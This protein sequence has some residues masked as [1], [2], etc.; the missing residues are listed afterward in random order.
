MV[1]PEG[2]ARTVVPVG[3][4]SRAAPSLAALDAYLATRPGLG[5]AYP[6]FVSWRG[7][8]TKQVLNR[9]ADLGVL[10]ALPR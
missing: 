9:R 8:I 6:L 10:P 1:R 7:H 5:P 3:D 2:A 4:Y